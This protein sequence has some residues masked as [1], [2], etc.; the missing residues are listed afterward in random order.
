[1]PGSPGG[2]GVREAMMILLLT[3]VVGAGAAVG[4]SISMRLTNMLG[5]GVAFLLGLASRRWL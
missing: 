5:D 2:V 4:L 1:V 3:P